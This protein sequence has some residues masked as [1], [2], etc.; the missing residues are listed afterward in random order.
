MKRSPS[1]LVPILFL[2]AAATTSL[3]GSPKVH[4]KYGDFVF[5]PV[6]SIAWQ[7]EGEGGK[8]V[9]IIAMTDFKVDRPP[10]IEALST[11]NAL[12]AQAYARQKGTILLISSTR[13][14]RCD[15]NALLNAGM[16]QVGLIA[17]VSGLKE[18]VK[19]V[20]GRCRTTSP[21]KLFDTEYEFD[22][23]WDIDLAP[24]PRPEH[25]PAGG[26]EPGKALVA[27]VK[28]IQAHDWNT[29]NLHLRESESARNPKPAERKEFFEMLQL[30]YPK[31]A[32]VSG[33]IIKG[34]YASIEMKGTDR[35]SKKIRGT[36]TMI[37][38][39]DNWR[40]DDQ[41]LYTDF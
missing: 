2:L 9:T 4:F 7:E 3:A 14:E 5:D 10:L 29:A 13:P 21:Q 16:N 30:N 38:V 31:T 23:N 25:L 28:A 40:V 20:V 37:K 41:Q 34:K 24:I 12:L 27:V 6:D 15:V 19:H 36:F 18:G 11:A 33:G 17:D 32:I 39:G 22:L 35:E 8:T 26:G 1:V